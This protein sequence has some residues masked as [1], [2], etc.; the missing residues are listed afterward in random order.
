MKFQKIMFSGRITGH[1][2]YFRVVR[3]EYAEAGSQLPK[4]SQKFHDS[5][6]KTVKR[7]QV[8]CK[9]CLSKLWAQIRS[10]Y[11]ITRHIDVVLLIDV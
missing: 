4:I 11:N 9:D 8:E 3:L 5:E 6:F 7:F 10:T 1:S 2:N